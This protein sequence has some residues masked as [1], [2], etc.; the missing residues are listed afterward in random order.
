[1]SSLLM[2]LSLAVAMAPPPLP[3]YPDLHLENVLSFPLSLCIDGKPKCLASLAKGGQLSFF[4]IITVRL[5]DE[6][7]PKLP[8]RWLFQ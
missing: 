5:V 8:L 4:C 6:L 1:M 7:G 3:W 2:S